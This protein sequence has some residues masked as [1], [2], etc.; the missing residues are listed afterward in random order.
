MAAGFPAA[1]FIWMVSKFGSESV[2][3]IGGDKR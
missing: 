1:F 3:I 2:I